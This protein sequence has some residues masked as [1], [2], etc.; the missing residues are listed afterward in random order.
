MTYVLLGIRLLILGVSM[1]G[2]GCLLYDKT[3][4]N[5]AFLP[6]L[7]IGVITTG[8]YA[9]GL[10]NVLD[11]GVCFFVLAGGAAAVYYGIRALRKR[12]S[13]RPLFCCGTV[14][15]AV[16]SAVL[17]LL[18][19]GVYYDHYDNFS[20]WGLIVKELFRTN[21]YPTDASGVTFANYPP[22]PRPSFITSAVSSGIAKAM[23]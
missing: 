13:F 7:V 3:N 11:E 18:L 9:A 16:A 14:F 20:H 19:R 23:R 12:F 15:F 17:F 5:P 4:V 1:V 10:L 8:M 22:G 6:V 2:I 21:S